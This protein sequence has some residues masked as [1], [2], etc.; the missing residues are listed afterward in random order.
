MFP[1]CTASKVNE[2]LRSDEDDVKV[3]FFSH[4]GCGCEKMLIA[5]PPKR[6]LLVKGPF[7][8]CTDLP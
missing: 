1:S 8:Q 3:H 2:L 6:E 7:E 5:L 4:T